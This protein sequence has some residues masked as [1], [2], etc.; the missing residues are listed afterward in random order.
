MANNARNTQPSNSNYDFDIN[1]KSNIST[2]S[3][4]ADIGGCGPQ[5]RIGAD[6]F[7]HSCIGSAVLKVLLVLVLGIVR[8]IALNFES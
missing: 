7:P 3:R 6:L 5:R 4:L 1:V 8:C 2:L